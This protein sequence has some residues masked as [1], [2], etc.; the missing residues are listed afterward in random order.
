M[1]YET[2]N[3]FRSVAS[4]CQKQMDELLA[5][6]YI[7]LLVLRIAEKFTYSEDDPQYPNHSEPERSLPNEPT[8][9]N[10]QIP[11]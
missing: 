7:E 1:I 9:S 10:N 3:A 6:L 11:H 8:E 4:E 2:M 5:K